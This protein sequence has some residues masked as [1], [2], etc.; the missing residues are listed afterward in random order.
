VPLS[1]QLV[2]LSFTNQN[3]VEFVLLS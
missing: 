2:N 1:F 3:H